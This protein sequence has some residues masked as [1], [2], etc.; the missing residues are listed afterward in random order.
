VVL[1][2]CQAARN[3]GIDIGFDIY[4][5]EWAPGPMYELL[6]GWALEGTGDEVAQRFRDVQFRE[7]IIREHR[8]NI[9]RWVQL[10]AWD[11][12][13]IVG[14]PKNPDVVNKSLAQLADEWRKDP[15]DVVF[16]LLAEAGSNYPEITQISRTLDWEDILLTIA[17]PMCSFGS[18]SSTLSRNHPLKNET[19]MPGCYG[20]VP[21][22]FDELVSSRKALSFEEAVRRLTS[23]PASQLGLWDRGIIRPGLKADLALI[24]PETFQDNTT[25]TDF[26]ARPG[27]VDLVV[28]SG[29]IAVENGH[30]TG[31]RAGRVLRL[32]EATE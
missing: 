6:P 18:D 16:E 17:D 23:L 5:Y 20:F 7:K 15:W 12:V 1:D 29:Q 19:F 24:N 28:I 4:P 10:D 8:K 30:A 9:V 31:V 22:V 26:N 27:G 13:I 25:W 2:L 32:K 3:K 14:A 11:K 21:R